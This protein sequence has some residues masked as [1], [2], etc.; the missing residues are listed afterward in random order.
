[1]KDRLKK[2]TIIIGLLVVFLSTNAFSQEKFNAK[3]TEAILISVAMLRDK[4]ELKGDEAL[5]I[6]DKAEIAKF[7]KLFD[8]NQK[9]RLHACGY[10]WRIT[11]VRKSAE[12][13]DIWFNQACEEFVKK[14]EEIC[15]TVQ[16]KFS[17]IK[18]NPTHFVTDIGIDVNV[19]PDEVINKIKGIPNF[20]L[21]VLGDLDKRFPFI[22]IESKAVSEIP[23]DRK[24]W[25]KAKNETR[26]KAET[27]LTDESK[28]LSQVFAV[29]KN[30]EFQPSMSMFGGGKIEENLKLKIFFQ[31][32]TKM[33][34]IEKHLTEAKFIRKNE[35]QVYF[36][37]L[38]TSNR[39]SDSSAKQLSQN[40]SFIKETFAYTSWTR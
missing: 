23:D 12:P 22:E 28:R 6:S 7:V 2:L 21:F 20:K 3:D 18:K 8:G 19:P 31:V 24:L 9:S 4:S 40:F 13:T 14:S 1:M 32:G 37:Q 11:F 33:E 25:E 16:A 15:E 34:G 27:I 30:G 5:L 10:Q 39:F 17:Q 36:L 35:P 38:V 26:Q 29:L